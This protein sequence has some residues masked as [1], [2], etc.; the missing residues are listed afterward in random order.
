[1]KLDFAG[2]ACGFSQKWLR[3]QNFPLLKGGVPEGWGGSRVSAETFEKYFH[4][5]L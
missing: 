2:P 4:L 1:M 3:L 5:P